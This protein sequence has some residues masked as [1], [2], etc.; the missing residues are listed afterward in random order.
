MRC[1]WCYADS[2]TVEKVTVR[3]EPSFGRCYGCDRNYNIIR[4]PFTT[5][6]ELEETDATNL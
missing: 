2:V 1:P 4:I 3:D 5:E 6:Y